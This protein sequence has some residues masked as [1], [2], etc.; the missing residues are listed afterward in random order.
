MPAFE[1]IRALDGTQR[2]T[3]FATFLGPTLDAFDCFLLVV[4]TWFGPE[5][6]GVRFGMTDAAGDATIG[7][8]E[9]EQ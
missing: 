8:P 6:H 1:G 3:V 5:A 7:G 2:H 9:V 4:L